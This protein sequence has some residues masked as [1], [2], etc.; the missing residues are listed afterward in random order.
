[1]IEEAKGPYRYPGLDLN[2]TP[3]VGSELQQ[4]GYIRLA[5]LILCP[6][7]LEQ[8]ANRFQILAPGVFS[9]ICTGTRAANGG[10]A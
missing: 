4:I 3:A 8:S 6:S 2:G 7:L 5:P 1:M 9:E 10:K